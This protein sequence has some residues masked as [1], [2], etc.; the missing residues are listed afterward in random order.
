MLHS[1]HA[2]TGRQL[3]AGQH[4]R[5]FGVISRLAHLAQLGEDASSSMVSVLCCAVLCCAVLCKLLH[6]AILSRQRH[7]PSCSRCPV[8]TYDRMERACAVSDDGARRCVL[9]S[10]L[11]AASQSWRSQC[12]LSMHCFHDTGPCLVS[13]EYLGH[14]NSDQKMSV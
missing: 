1:P 5:P 13:C 2:K 4:V 10:F 12:S 9:H 8:Y 11:M 14:L 7:M 6:L 3:S